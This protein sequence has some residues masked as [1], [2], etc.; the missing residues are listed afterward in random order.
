MRQKNEKRT[1]CIK[2]CFTVLFLLTLGYF[3]AGELFLPSENQPGE[4]ICQVFD[5]EWYQVLGDGSRT[6]VKLPGKCPAKRNEPVTIET[7]LPENIDNGSCLC[8]YSVRQDVWFYVEGELRQVYTTRDS[9]WVGETS[10]ARYLFLELS[11][12]DAGKVLQIVTQTN[13]SY[14]G[15]F[16]T[17]YYGNQ[18]GIWRFLLRQHGLE[19]LVAFIMLL[20]GLFSVVGSVILHFCYHEGTELEYLGWAVALASIWILCNSDLRQLIFP[21]ATMLADLS[22]FMIML[23]PIPFMIYM[24]Q[25]Q[26]RRYH[27]WYFVIELLAIVDTIVC[28]ALQMLHIKDF[29]DTIVFMAVVCLLAILL[30]SGTMILDAFHK[31]LRE[32]RLTAI[33]ILG[34]CL[35]A[36]AQIILYFWRTLPFNAIL[37]SLGLSFLLI[38]SVINTIQDVLSMEKEKQQAILDSESKARFLANMSHEIRTPINAVLGMDE[39]ILRETTEEKIRGYAS[40]IRSAGKSLLGLVNDILDFSKIEFGKMEIVSAEYEVCSLLNDCYNLIFMRARDKK[41]IFRVENDPQ[42]PKTLLGDE[43]RVRQIIVN[44]LTNAVKYTHEGSVIFSLEGE[45]LDGERLLLKIAVRDTGIGITEEN[46]EKLFESFQRVDESRNRNIE[47]TGL[48]LAITK[49][50]V[51]LMEGKIWLESTYGKG[52]AFYVEIEQKIVDRTP[53]GNFS[54]GYSVSDEGEKVHSADIYAPGGRILVVDDV[55][56]NLKVFTMLLKNTGLQIDTAESGSQ[57]LALVKKNVYH[58]IFLDHMMPEM[59]G[60][61]TLAQL[62]Q[63]PEFSM[64][65]PVIMLTAN[66]ILGAREE[67]LSKGFRDYLAKPVQSAE[68]EKM[69]AEYLPKEFLCGDNQVSAEESWKNVLSFLNVENG[70]HYSAGNK[71]LYVEMLHLF[72][73][74]QWCESLEELYQKKDWTNYKIKAH[75]L[76][77]TSRSIGADRLSEVAKQLETAAKALEAGQAEEHEIRNL[78]GAVMRECGELLE[79]LAHCISQV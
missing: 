33:G 21:N 19:F 42:L 7:V 58:M 49:Q 70:I 34:A 71:E 68:L 66:A 74:E 10:V 67:Y 77:S 72:L 12:A 59:D 8:L 29:T 39:M 9:R 41:L 28:T 60:V 62:R 31:H 45:L 1:L 2:A 38:V 79:R 24:N 57:C 52:S 61:E 13:T 26:R 73:E 64:E 40:D 50:L 55:P 76:K 17:M 37:M 15:I 14:T 30:N 16:R 20:L 25:V 43:V 23:L 63:L 22:Y 53:V 32:Y 47:G 44:L 3:V 4:Y 18:M 5:A 35:A 78:H 11:A 6:P 65:T 69:L 75:A 46:Q 51:D 27:V 54:S 48:G 56:M 36:M